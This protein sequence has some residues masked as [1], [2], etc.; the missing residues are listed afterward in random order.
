M[1]W[2]A[3]PE[4]QVFEVTTTYD[5]DSPAYFN[6]VDVHEEM[7]R[8][9]DLCHGCRLCWDLCPSFD[10][11]FKLIDAKTNGVDVKL[12]RIDSDRIVDECYQCKLC[13]IKCPYVPPHEWEL[14]FPRLMLRARAARSRGRPATLSDRFLG[15]TDLTGKIGTATSGIAN[16][17]NRSKP[18]RVVMEKTLGVARERKLPD[19]TKKRFSTWFKKEGVARAPDKGDGAPKATLF[20]TCLVEYNDPSIGKAAI[21]ILGSCGVGVNCPAT[22][23]CGMPS[24]DGGDVKGFIEKANRNV[25]ILAPHAR[26]GRAII[27][28]QPTCGYVLRHEYPE[29]LKSGDAKVVAE[30]TRD[31]GEYIFELKKRG[32]FMPDFK[33]ELGK[34][35]YHA[36]CHLRAQGKGLKGRD[37]LKTVP[38]TKVTLI[39]GCTGIDGT[40]GY[41]AQWY[42]MARKVAKPMVDRIEKSEP[43]VIVGDCL[44][45]DTAIEEETGMRPIHPLH[46]IARALGMKGEV[47]GE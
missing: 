8:V 45:A 31:A 35:A 13:Y 44:L 47:A 6:E 9:F 7:D 30:A 18:V 21:E 25:E 32:V 40:W 3:G 10:S 20:P 34:V 42:E 33:V 27:V 23:C 4:S 36:P 12:D 39:E 2:R 26:A 17:A 29:Y 1:G 24:L 37:V 46:A 38:G 5:P 43:D 16:A 41:K 15:A 11:L 22:V 19:Y 28:P 14:D